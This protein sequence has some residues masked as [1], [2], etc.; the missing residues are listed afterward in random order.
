MCYCSVFFLRIVSTHEKHDSNPLRRAHSK[1]GYDADRQAA[2][3]GT[4]P[5]SPQD[6][7]FRQGRLVENP[8]DADETSSLISRESSSTPGDIR[9]RHG[10]AKVGTDHDPHIDIRNFAM[11]PHLQFWQLWLNLGLLT[12]IGLMTIK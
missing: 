3:L 10:D 4:P 2:E 6:E 12:G 1:D 7:S 8:E 11:L 9:E 5:G